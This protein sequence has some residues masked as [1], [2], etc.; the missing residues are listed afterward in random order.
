MD[1]IQ[2]PT[3]IF[4]I[5]LDFSLP[6]FQRASKLIQIT[7][8]TGIQVLTCK[9]FKPLPEFQTSVQILGFNQTGFRVMT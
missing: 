4:K 8:K 6:S 5:K 3:V 9:V 1:G 2:I 7:I